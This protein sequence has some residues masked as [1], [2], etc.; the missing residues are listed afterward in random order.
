MCV[1]VH[2]IVW[3]VSSSPASHTYLPIVLCPEACATALLK[4]Y[5]RVPPKYHICFSFPDFTLKKKSYGPSISKNPQ[6]AFWTGSSTSGSGLLILAGCCVLLSLW[7]SQ[8][9]G[10]LGAGC[11]Q[12]LMLVELTTSYSVNYLLFWLRSYFGL[13]LDT[14]ICT[15][16]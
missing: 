5:Y 11:A 8:V 14:R 13:G 4:H 2:V 9:T 3:H 6:D 7:E 10:T 16:R 15:N 12:L 1:R